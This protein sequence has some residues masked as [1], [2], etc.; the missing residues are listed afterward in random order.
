[1]VRTGNEQV[2]EFYRRLGYTRDEVINL[3]KRLVED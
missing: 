3:G 1:M 2:I